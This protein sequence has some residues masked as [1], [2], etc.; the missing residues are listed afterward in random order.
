M[1]VCINAYNQTSYTHSL[2]QTFTHKLPWNISMTHSTQR[3]K[4]K[5]RITSCILNIFLLT[6]NQRGRK[7]K[8]KITGCTCMYINVYTYKHT[9]YIL[10]NTNNNNNNN[11]NK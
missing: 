11:N 8:G 5:K 2:P 4:R 7:R 3:D 10:A 1:D 6:F 9:K